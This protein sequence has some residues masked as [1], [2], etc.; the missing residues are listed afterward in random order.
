MSS[1]LPASLSPSASLS[2]RV[3][4]LLSRMTTAEKI[5]QTTLVAVNHIEREAISEMGIGAILSGGGGNPAENTPAAWHEMVSSCLQAGLN[6]RLGIPLLYGVDAVHGHNNVR[7][8]V[9]FPHNIGLGAARDAD[10]V[11]R[12]AHATAV[13]VYATAVRWNYAPTLAV[14]QDIRWGRTYEGFSEDSALVSELGAAYV[15]GLQGDDLTAE[16]SVLATPKHFLGDGA[17]EWG[18]ATFVFPV[19]PMLGIHE[20]V[21]FMLDQGE[22]YIS[23]ETLRGVHLA[24]YQSALRAGAQ[25]VMASFSSWQGIKLHTHHY[26][27]TDLLKGEL[28]FS[29]FIVSDWEGVRDSDPDPYMAVV[30]CFNAGLDMTMIT[31]DYRAKM[32]LLEQAVQNGDVPLSRLDDA[33]RRILTVKMRAGLFDNP[34]TSDRH[35]PLVGCAEHRALAREAVAKSAVLLKNDRQALP[36][37]RSAERILVA[38][39]WADDIGLQ[40]G[41]WTIAWQ[42][43]AGDITQG[44]SF[45]SAMRELAG[46]QTRIEFDPAGEF[47]WLESAGTGEQAA[48]LGVVL[49]GEHPYAEGHGDRE[50]L[51]L[52][53]QQAALIERMRR[54]CA[55]LVAVIISGRPLIITE[56]LPLV[57]ALVAAW[58]PGS[59]LQGLADVLF[60][61]RPFSGKLPYTWPRTMDQIPLEKAREGDPLFPFG[62]GLS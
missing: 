21:P 10:L 26:L 14:P 55:A 22:A 44:T 45:L 61:D 8:A 59:E 7:G 29:G 12:V 28:G 52:D 13:E 46:P 4:D 62:Y 48:E 3:E 33:V 31:G 43:Q 34:E 15:A 25:I 56:Q 17:T 42:G 54:R 57:D 20:P 58:L 40:C 36:L 35:L 6:S 27:L 11:R 41:G 32:A 5:G 38:G 2:A 9:I 47:T 19:V 53:K 49:I 16:F 60:G 50:D 23:E 37:S 18:S 39:A 30:S 51:N 24:P 1:T